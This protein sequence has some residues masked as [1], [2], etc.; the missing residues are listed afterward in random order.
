MQIP[1]HSNLLSCLIAKTVVA[2][3]KTILP[4]FFSHL[5]HLTCFSLHHISSSF[6][7]FLALVL[8]SSSHLPPAFTQCEPERSVE[9]YRSPSLPNP[10]SLIA[11]NHEN[12]W[13]FGFYTRLLLGRLHTSF[14]F[15]SINSP[16]SLCFYAFHLHFYCFIAC[17]SLFPHS[18]CL[19]LFLH[20][21]S[22]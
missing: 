11:N 10:F 18:V 21:S 2:P 4:L 16:Y 6:L 20:F 1:P 13:D 12:V 3:Q 14:P 19:H 15:S 22:S 17:S 5:N 9:K 8:F 7:V